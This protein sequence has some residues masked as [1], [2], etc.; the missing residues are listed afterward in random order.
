MWEGQNLFL[1]D[2]I[3]NLMK[4]L[5]KNIYSIIFRISIEFPK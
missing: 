1:S 5:S 2:I 3:I 4:D